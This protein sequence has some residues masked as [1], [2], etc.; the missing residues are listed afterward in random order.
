MFWSVLYYY[1]IEVNIKNELGLQKICVQKDVRSKKM[2]V[3][4]LF[5]KMSGQKIFR[6]NIFLSLTKVWVQEVV[7]Q[8][9]LD[10]KKCWDQK[11]FGSKKSCV[12]KD[13]WVQKDLGPKKFGCTIMGL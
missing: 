12:Q 5:K 10:P 11:N 9:I 8:K 1:T 13:F 2:R 7:A 6:V 4:K 3:Q